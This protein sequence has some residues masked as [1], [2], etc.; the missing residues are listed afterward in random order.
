MEARQH[1]GGVWYGVYAVGASMCCMCVF[2]QCMGRAGRMSL[3]WR[4]TA[5]WRAQESLGCV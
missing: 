1:A 3:V 5:S 4:E 2:V